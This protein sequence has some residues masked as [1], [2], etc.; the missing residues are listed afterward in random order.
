MWASISEI[1]VDKNI[2]LSINAKDKSTVT[3]TTNHLDKYLGT[4]LMKG[5]LGCPSIE[6][7][8]S[9]FPFVYQYP[10]KKH[11][12]PRKRFFK[13]SK[14][15]KI[16]HKKIHK[17]L[18][19]NFQTHMQASFYVCIDEVRI[20]CRH[21]LCAF[22]KYNTKKPD[23]WAIESKSLNDNNGY[24][25]DF[26]YPCTPSDGKS[27][28]RALRRFFAYLEATGR[29]HN[30]TMDSNF[31]SAGEISGYSSKNITIL[32]MCKK[33][34]PSWLWKDGLGKN[35]PRSYTR[36]VK[37]TASPPIVAACTFNN[38][39]CNLVSNFFS[40]TD[41]EELYQPSKRRTMLQL[42]DQTKGYGDKFGQIVK[43]YYPAFHFKNW[44]MTLLIGWFKY[45]LTNSYI[46]FTLNGG[47]L[48][49]REFLHQIA[50]DLMDNQEK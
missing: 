12:M 42:Y 29:N 50:H 24:L 34:R 46:L 31:I 38:G 33:S 49:H 28:Q 40:V 37:R 45:A 20:A 2:D 30:V 35:L 39:F 44:E 27:I 26:T 11:Q 1:L 7:L 36:V 21:Y 15:L 18:V 5:V 41:N 8:W 3:L 47:E 13:I 43:S 32:A 22:K 6:D 25:L 14:N 23:V 19:K 16:P 9:K 17:T 48:T 10:G 4:V